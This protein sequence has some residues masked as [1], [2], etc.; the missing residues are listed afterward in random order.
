MHIEIWASWEAF[1]KTKCEQ[2]LVKP[3][4]LCYFGGL[5]IVMHR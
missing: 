2:T 5:V 3:K 4:G 1:S